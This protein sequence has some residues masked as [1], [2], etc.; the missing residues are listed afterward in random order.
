MAIDPLA[1]RNLARLNDAAADTLVH[2]FFPSVPAWHGIGATVFRDRVDSIGHRRDE[3]ADAHREAAVLLHA[4][5]LAAQGLLDEMAWRG[6]QRDNAQERVASLRSALGSTVDPIQVQRLQAQLA[7]A[8]SDRQRAVDQWSEVKADLSRRERA[9]AHSVKGLADLHA[10][11]SLA[12]RLWRLPLADFTAYRQLVAAGRIP[13]ESLNWTND[14][15]SDG[16]LI[17][18]ES[19]DDSCI[20]HDFGYRNWQELSE[21]K[22][23]AKAMVDQQFGRDLHDVCGQMPVVSV[24]DALL[25]HGSIRL[26]CEMM[27]AE[28][29]VGVTLV[30]SPDAHETGKKRDR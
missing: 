29:F 10:L 4:F 11:P 28:A 12:G 5:S 27:A 15:C 3:L 30:G 13:T 1:V 17:T 9:C 25:G 24:P 6:R 14:G 26:D 19:S 7:E 16:H 23:H 20:R 18:S 22:D 8:I 2:L 21:V